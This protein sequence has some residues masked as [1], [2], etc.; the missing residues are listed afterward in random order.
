MELLHSI[1]WHHRIH[2][3][4]EDAW[5]TRCFRWLIDRCFLCLSPPNSYFFSLF[6]QVRSGKP[7]K[8]PWKGLAWSIQLWESHRIWAEEN[9]NA[10][11]EHFFDY[12]L[13]LAKYSIRLR[14]TSTWLQLFP[15]VFKQTLLGP[16]GL[17]RSRWQS[18]HLFVQEE[19]FQA[20]TTRSSMTHQS[21][22][23]PS[24]FVEGG[25][26]PGCISVV[27]PFDFRQFVFGM[28]MIMITTVFP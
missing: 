5:K 6:P 19:K 21:R 28:W 2:W 1:M 23:M 24:S 16:M 4:L 12:L 14:G 15:I 20:Q 26:I 10:I 7:W 8:T 3:L 27:F 25:P 17:R 9:L 22:Q 18:Q 11:S 13:S